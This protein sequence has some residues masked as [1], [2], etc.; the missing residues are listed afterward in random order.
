MKYY[1]ATKRNSLGDRYLTQDHLMPVYIIKSAEAEGR[2]AGPETE[3]QWRQAQ[4]PSTCPA[5]PGLSWLKPQARHPPGSPPK[6]VSQWDLSTPIPAHSL[7]TSP[8]R[9]PA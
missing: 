8:T 6:A 4:P 3:P 7:S 1:S 2:A 9:D 5:G